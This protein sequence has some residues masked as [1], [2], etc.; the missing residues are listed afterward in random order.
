MGARLERLSPKQRLY[1]QHLRGLL[2]KKEEEEKNA[3]LAF[4]NDIRIR[5]MIAGNGGPSAFYDRSIDSDVSVIIIQY[6]NQNIGCFVRLL[7]VAC[8]CDP[9]PMMMTHKQMIGFIALQTNSMRPT[10]G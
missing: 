10:D 3:K 8:M 2:D 1:L 7:C 9:F 4:H 5:K 6:R